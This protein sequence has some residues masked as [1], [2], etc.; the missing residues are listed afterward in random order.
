VTSALCAWDS[1]W[2]IY[3]PL[4]AEHDIV[5]Y[6]YMIFKHQG[7]HERVPNRVM[8][9]TESYPRDVYSNYRTVK[10]HSYIIGDF[11]W[12]A[13]DYLGE[14]GIG[15]WFYKGEVTGESWQNPMFPNH[16]AYCGDIDLTGLRK[17]ISHRRSMLWNKDG[18]HLYMAVREPDGYLGTVNTTQW[19]VW[20]TYESWNW[21]G[22]RNGEGN[23]ASW[24]GKPVT[25]EVYS[26]Y[27]EVRLSLNGQ[28]IEQHAVK[29]GMT[30]FT[31]PYQ[32][33]T[34]VAEG[35][36][37][38]TV[39]ESVSLKTAGTPAAIK[40]TPDG[41]VDDPA[42]FNR[43]VGDPARKT[44][45]DLLFVTVELQDAAGLCVPDAANRLTA[46]VSGP[47]RLL[48]F[49]NADIKDC[50]SYVDNSHRLWKGRALLVL[51]SNGRRGTVRLTVS[52]DGLRPAT[53]TV[54]VR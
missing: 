45:Q 46:T 35:L 54:P 48:A 41:N 49:G 40:L 42:L 7:D 38:G 30:T 33:G 4:A 11:V 34:L 31:L 9:Q 32:P 27:P 37:G 52:G 3:D 1:D 15:R 44:S 16:A 5:G 14:S 8:M 53:L 29:D 18:E 51:R 17:P 13:I 43:S 2:D 47:A 28:V 24:V 26:H 23:V 6:N 12:T 50:D 36:E 10:D 20:P 25:V 22:S 21:E 39:R 19:S